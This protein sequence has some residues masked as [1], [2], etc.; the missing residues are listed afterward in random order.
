MP[1]LRMAP[2]NPWSLLHIWAQA[3]LT[4]RPQGSLVLE[5][6]SGPWA[7]VPR[8]VNHGCYGNY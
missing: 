7:P 2:R 1:G 8:A 6:L 5:R 3:Q 4:Q